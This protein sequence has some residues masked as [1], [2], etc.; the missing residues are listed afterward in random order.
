M[1]SP[2][3]ALFE[4]PLTPIQQWFFEV[5]ASAPHHLNQSVLLAGGPTLPRAGWEAV[6]DAVLAH[7]DALR[8]RF[9]PDGGTWR[10]YYL[11]H[12]SRRAFMEVDLSATGWQWQSALE[13]ATARLQRSLNL[14]DGPLVRIVSF[15]GPTRSADRMF[16]VV[17]RAVIDAVSWRILLEDI[18]RA[19][20]QWKAGLPIHL[21]EKTS[22]F[23][24][25]ADHL[26]TLTLDD[27]TSAYW[28]GVEARLTAAHL[29]RDTTGVNSIG[30]QRHVRVE[31]REEETRALLEQP[32]RAYRMEADEVLVAAVAATLAGWTGRSEAVLALE[33][34]G[35]ESEIEGLNLSRTVGCFTSMFPVCV[36]VPPGGG[37]GAILRAVRDHLDGV[38]RRGLDYGLWRY[39]VAGS[40]RP[41]ATPEVMVTCLGEFDQ[42][43]DE[44]G[45]VLGTESMGRARHPA[46]PRP[47]V[48]EVTAGIIK[49][50]FTVRIGYSANLHWPETIDTFGHALAT[51]LRAFIRHCR[52]VPPTGRFH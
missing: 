32:L 35:R 46:A 25:W 12:E 45:S 4:V 3:N 21:P 43:L 49:G 48:L 13:S 16:I 14:T 18:H 10:Q 50:R 20:A 27:A 44:G 24:R 31:L 39:G 23:G 7:H 17:H 9:T 8:L 6:V 37:P 52:E 36:R 40:D 19:S 1:T 41:V 29:P 15:R 47:F 2:A 34:H 51:R 5:Q 42:V 28:Q 38:P 11:A 33:G 22:S 30:S 26:Q